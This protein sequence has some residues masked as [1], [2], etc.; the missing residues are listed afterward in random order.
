MLTLTIIPKINNGF[1]SGPR[2]GVGEAKTAVPNSYSLCKSLSLHPWITFGIIR[3][4]VRSG[5]NRAI[6]FII[7][8]PQD[9]GKGPEKIKKIRS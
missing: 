2:G 7:I 5:T 3:G 1:N 9:Q 6:F 8:F 4:M